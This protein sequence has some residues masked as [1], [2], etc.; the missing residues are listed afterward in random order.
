MPPLTIQQAYELALSHHREARF[1]EA[2]SIYRQVLARDPAHAD[3]LQMLGVLAAQAGRGTEALH[4]L[5][6]A[7]ALDPGAPEYHGNL[8]IVLAGQGKLDEAISAFLKALELRP[9]YVQAQ[10][11]LARALKD[12]GQLQEAIAGFRQTLLAQP[13][14]PEAHYHLAEALR[15]TGQMN[16]A[17]DAYQRAVELRPGTAEVYNNCA[18]ALHQAGRSVEAIAALRQ[19]LALRQNFP[20]ALNNLGNVLTTAGHADEGIAAYRQAIALRADYPDAYY[21]LGIA[22]KNQG[23]AG[24]AIAAFG[25]AAELRPNHP[26]VHNNLGNALKDCGQIDGAI[27]C[28]RRAL[29]LGGDWW[30]GSNLLYALHFHPDDDPRR[31][32]DE[33]ARWNERFARPLAASIRPHDNNLDPDRRLRI[34]YISPHFRNHPIGLF[35]QP[36]LAHHDHR[37]FEIFCYADLSRADAMT[38][39]LRPHADVWRDTSNQSDAQLAEMIRKDQIDVL[40]D[41]SMHMKGS[42]IMVFA[43]KPAPVQVTYLAYCSTTGLETIDYRLTDP[44]LD[45]PGYEGNYSERSVWLPRSYWCYEPHPQAA[46]VGPLPALAADHVTFGCL[47]NYAKVSPR[48]IAAWTRILQS[49]PHSRLVLHSNEGEHRLNVREQF[50]RDGIGPDRVRF[51]DMLPLKQY[52]DQYNQIDIAL[53]PFPYPG[54]TTTCDAL[55]MGAPVVSLAGRTAVSRA[56]LSILSNIGLPELVAREPAQY[57]LIALDLAR[58]LPRLAELRAT[59]RSRMRQS[60]LMDAARFTREVEASFRQMWCRKCERR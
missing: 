27:A 44:Y 24:D 3:A 16:A 18:S 9:A 51:V 31:I 56:G 7:V 32:G 46:D 10:F 35:L 28:Y 4:L 11:N 42:R 17:I 1:A 15:E 29:E 38:D 36:L 39:R 30:V 54:G 55:W 37:Q 48:A 8:G 43:R 53:D 58:D 57:V 33:H 13:D 25:R 14:L 5:R 49:V 12:K 50:Q 22:L 47:N 60:P 59:M 20:E 34:G 41:L 52:L 45:P 2:E 19:A 23:R 21:N 6:R 26:D 40:V